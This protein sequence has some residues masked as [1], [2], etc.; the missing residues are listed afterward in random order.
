M[1][2]NDIQKQLLREI[3]DLETVPKGAYNI[4]AN[5]ESAGRSTTANIDIVTKTDKP[6]IDIIIK[7][8]TKNESIHIPVIISQHGLKEM[9]YNDFIVGEGADVTI[10]AG[11]GIHNCGDQDSSHDG[12]HSFFVGKNARIR[13]IEKHYGEGDGIGGKIMNPTTVIELAEGAVMEMES[14]QIK[15]IDSTSRKTVAKLADGA[16]LTVREKIMTHGEQLAETDFTIDMDGEDCACHL[17]SR[18]VA[19]DKSRQIFR[20]NVKGNNRCTGHSECD[21]I[22]MDDALVS[23]IPEITASHVDASLIHEA[24]IG[25]IAGE[26][27][28]KLMTLGLT[29]K[30]AEEQIVNGFLK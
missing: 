20:S 16:S 11:C 27:L 25:K 28:M 5:G 12:I 18:S 10:I 24:A 26:Q 30:E 23:A 3:A 2:L 4:R 15:G 29:E 8:G 19:K 14:T 13:Y 21:A 1:S 17:I 22:I 7:P 9:V 6:G